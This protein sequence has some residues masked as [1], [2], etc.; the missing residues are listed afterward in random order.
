MNKKNEEREIDKESSILNLLVLRLK[1]ILYN[2][3]VYRN[4]RIR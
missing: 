4:K 3:N 1:V 2:I